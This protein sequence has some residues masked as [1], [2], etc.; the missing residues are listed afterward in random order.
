MGKTQDN[1]LKMFS[2]GSESSIR[3]L[4][5]ADAADKEGHPGVSKIFRAVAK[6]KQFHSLSHFRAAKLVDTTVENLK[7]AREEE[8][9]DYKNACPP[10]VQDAKAEGALEARHSL[11]Y[12]MSIGPII[13]KLISKAI[14]NLDMKEDGSYFICPV[15]GNIEYGKPPAKCPFCGVDAGRFEELR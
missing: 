2:S 14:G 1:L 9:Y 6:A 12:A 13:A 3:Y 15:C 10:M 4:A 5:F 7:Q 8:S 11:E